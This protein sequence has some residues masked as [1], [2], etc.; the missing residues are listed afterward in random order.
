MADCIAGG[1]FR[2]I[3]FGGDSPFLGVHVAI[4]AGR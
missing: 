3:P 2:P 4:G 1:T